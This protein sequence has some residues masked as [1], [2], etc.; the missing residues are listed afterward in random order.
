[1]KE[2]KAMEIINCILAEMRAIDYGVVE[3]IEAEKAEAK[4]ESK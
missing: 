2:P 4:G 3:T 1:M